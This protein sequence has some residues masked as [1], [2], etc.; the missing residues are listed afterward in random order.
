M[1]AERM[2]K[3]F[4]FREITERT[5]VYGLVGFPLSHSVSPSMHNAAFGAAG[6][7]AVY[8]PMPAANAA[9]FLEFANML[10]IRGASVTIPYKVDLFKLID[11]ADQVSTQ[12]GAVNTLKR[13]QTK[14][15]GR[16]TDV[17]GF[18]APLKGRLQLRGIRAAILGA[19]GAARGVAV[20]LATSGAEVSV[21]AR[22]TGRAGDVSRL[23][24]RKP[25]GLPLPPAGS[26]DL[27]VNATPLGAYPEVDRSPFPSTAFDGRMA[28]DLVYNPLETRFLKD[29]GAAGCEV[30]GGLD[31]LVA[32]AEDQSEWWTGRRPAPGLMREAAMARL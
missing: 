24:S 21:Y 19:G 32:Q 22:D 28:Y 26:W 17:N 13:H 15:L 2:L 11:A 9:D 6:V 30:I 27:L 29:A 8:V 20:A 25:T 4:R 31:M 18:L 16:N 1:P 10:H 23:V 3:E 14:W 12:V 5:A 7:D